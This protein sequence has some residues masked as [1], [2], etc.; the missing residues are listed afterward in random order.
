MSSNFK[1]YCLF[2]SKTWKIPSTFFSGF[3]WF[4]AN[5]N[6]DVCSWKKN[7]FDS[8]FALLLPLFPSPDRFIPF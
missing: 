3:D 2:E 8:L 1:I 5:W 7:S 6:A 4:T